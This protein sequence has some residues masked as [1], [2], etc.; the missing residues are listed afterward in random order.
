MTQVQINGSDTS[1][2]HLLHIDLPARAIERFTTMAGTG[3]WPLKY[4]LGA[5]KLSPAFVE[6]V[7]LRD[8]GNMSLSQ[9]LSEAY[10]L[11]PKALGSDRARVDG[12]DG[13]VVILPPQAF[14]N[15]SQEL[16]VNTPLSYIGGWS[17]AGAKGRSAS[18]RSSGAKGQ[19]SGGAPA[20]MG[21]LS[22]P[23]ILALIGLAVFVA[24]VLALVL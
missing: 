13:H 19:G 6:T 24:A 15:T 22:K 1:T 12:L 4:G 20:A 18:I 5:T 9:Y 2:V 10:D 21:S 11:P 16:H 17:A 7:D 23:I 8:L 14:E 3:E